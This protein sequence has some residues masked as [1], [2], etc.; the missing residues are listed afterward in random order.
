MCPLGGARQ[1]S[2]L[3]KP[4]G[5]IPR[6]WRATKGTGTMAPPWPRMPTGC[7]RSFLPPRLRRLARPH[8][9][10]DWRRQG[11][12]VRHF[13][14]GR[15]NRQGGSE[16]PLDPQPLRPSAEPTTAPGFGPR[17]RAGDQLLVWPPVRPLGERLGW[18]AGAATLDL[19]LANTVDTLAEHSEA[20]LA[21]AAGG[22]GSR[23][24]RCRRCPDGC[25]AN[26][27][28]AD[29]NCRYQKKAFRCSAAGLRGNR[30][31]WWTACWPGAR[32]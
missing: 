13:S 18:T 32:R 24:L 7:P 16:R 1:S 20:G 4:D 21:P 25:W 6:H 26:G 17:N 27:R 28:R 22:R 14:R 29:G 11:E 5:P 15:S 19:G 23:P 8:G 3:P 10:R 31:N 12:N 30:P 2:R 9:W